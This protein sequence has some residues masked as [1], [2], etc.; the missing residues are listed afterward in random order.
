MRYG[1]MR[2]APIWLLLL[3]PLAACVS[4]QPQL[5]SAPIKQAPTCKQVG[6]ASWYQGSSRGR[7]SRQD[8]LVAAHRTLPFGT[9]VRVTATETGRSVVV[10][11]NDRGPFNRAR[12]VDLSKMAA[13]QL[14]MR[15]DGLVRVQLEPITDAD[16]DCP[17]REATSE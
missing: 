12:I 10:R 13:D 14:G 16:K 5:T 6:L 9:L 15:A 17:F 1:T 11:I 2:M 3:L 7:T 8:D 4:P